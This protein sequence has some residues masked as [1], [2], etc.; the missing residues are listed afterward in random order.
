MQNESLFRDKPV[1]NAILTMAIPAVVSILIMVLYNMADM[2]FVG[3]LGGAD[4]APVAAVAV[5]G[6][7]FSLIM[8]L[9]TMIGVGGCA[10]IAKVAGAGETDTAKNYAS[11]CGWAAIL[12]GSVCGIVILLF[13]DP[14]LQFLGTLPEVMADA[15]A[16]MR[17]LAVG[18]PLMLFSTCYG[19]LLRAEGAIKDGF[20]GNM[21][22]TV[23]NLILDPLFIMVFRWGVAGAAAATVI[24]NLTAT[25]FYARFIFRK[26]SI[27]NL[28][29]ANAL[30]EPLALFG[31]LALGLPNAL[32]SILS[33]SAS[34]FSNQLLLN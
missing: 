18:A 21:T 20:I 32:S 8:S 22:G 7:V 29:P 31:I 33:G 15:G 17:I 24:G 1:W 11:L 9:A 13:T 16:Y 27:L 6:P 3:Q 28:L 30:Q 5:V 14:I 4:S 23:T 2:F 34:V 10:T 19:S 12:L 26:A 25:A